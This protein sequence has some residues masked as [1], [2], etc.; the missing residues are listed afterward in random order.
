[1]FVACFIFCLV[2][3]KC[4]DSCHIDDATTIGCSGHIINDM[5]NEDDDDLDDDDSLNVSSFGSCVDQ[6]DDYRGSID[7]K[8]L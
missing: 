2:M 7:K 5:D 8:S 6:L 4:Y 1:M 3:Q